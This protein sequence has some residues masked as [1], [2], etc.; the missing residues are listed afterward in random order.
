[1]RAGRPNW[2]SSGGQV[3]AAITARKGPNCQQS[4]QKIMIERV[5]LGAQVAA[6]AAFAA[7]ML[8]CCSMRAFRA[9][10]LENWPSG[11]SRWLGGRLAGASS[12]CRRAGQLAGGATFRPKSRRAGGRQLAAERLA[13]SLSPA[14]SGPQSLARHGPLHL[15]RRCWAANW[16]AGEPDL[17]PSDERRTTGFGRTHLAERRITRAPESSLAAAWPSGRRATGGELRAAS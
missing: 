13:G 11:A 1:M 17:L 16:A 9:A 5:C 14:V 8:A 3:R 10:Q 6:S 15:A 7:L 4:G 12:A 2:G